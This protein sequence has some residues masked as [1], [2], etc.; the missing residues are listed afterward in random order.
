[1]LKLYYFTFNQ[2]IRLAKLRVD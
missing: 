2:G 1:M